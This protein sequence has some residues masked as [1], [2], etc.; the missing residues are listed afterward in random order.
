MRT[1]TNTENFF[2]CNFYPMYK[3]L[4]VFTRYDS[5]EIAIMAIFKNVKT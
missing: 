5:Y 2:E 4:T 3:K 1:F